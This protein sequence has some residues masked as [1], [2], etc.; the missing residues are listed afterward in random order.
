MDFVVDGSG[1]D[2]RP[3]ARRGK[4]WQKRE[5]IELSAKSGVK[6]G[7]FFIEIDESWGKVGCFFEF[8]AIFQKGLS[9]FWFDF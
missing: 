8:L 4:A 6:V 1:R 2:C 9:R 3:N 5:K 7:W